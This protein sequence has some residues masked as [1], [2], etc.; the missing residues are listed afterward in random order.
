M[1]ERAWWKFSRRKIAVLSVLGCCSFALL[2]WTKLRLVTGVPR[3]AYADPAEEQKK[4]VKKKQ[5]PAPAATS[6]DPTQPYRFCQG[7]PT[8]SEIDQ[9]RR[10]ERSRK[11]ME[12]AQKANDA[13]GKSSAD[14]P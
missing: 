6:G 2:I 13:D 11:A 4:L 9:K 7:W 1:S 3:T 14:G 12:E 5:K 10:A 8:H